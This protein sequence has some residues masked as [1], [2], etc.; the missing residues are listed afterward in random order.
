MPKE[1]NQFARLHIGPKESPLVVLACTENCK[2]LGCVPN[3]EDLHIRLGGLVFY[4]TLCIR[5]RLCR[6][7]RS[8]VQSLTDIR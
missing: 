2:S 7:E 6:L 1:F 8:D 4:Q 5:K 3:V